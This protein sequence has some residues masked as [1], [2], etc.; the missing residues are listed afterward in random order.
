[1]YIAP[2]CD[3]LIQNLPS[4][5]LK[6]VCNRLPGNTHKTAQLYTCIT[7]QYVH[8][9]TVYIG[10]IY[11]ITIWTDRMYIVVTTGFVAIKE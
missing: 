1:M 6:T 4:M 3:I 11:Y 5:S 10:C 9:G 2:A 7:S 8:V